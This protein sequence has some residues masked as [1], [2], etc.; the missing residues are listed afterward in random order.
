MGS[1]TYP[2][3]AEYARRRRLERMPKPTIGDNCYPI[4]EHKFP[5]SILRVRFDPGFGLNVY[6]ETEWNGKIDQELALGIEGWDE[7]VELVHQ[8]D[9]W[10]EET[11]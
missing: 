7:L 1:T 10:V 11:P 6:I 5:D 9:R 3:P 4:L 8:Y 2:S